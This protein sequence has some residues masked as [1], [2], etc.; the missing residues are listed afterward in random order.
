MNALR[1][2]M[3]YHLPSRWTLKTPLGT[4]GTPCEH[5]APPSSP[6]RWSPMKATLVTPVTRPPRAGAVWLEGSAFT[7]VVTLPFGSTLEIRPPRTGSSVLPVY[8]AAA[9]DACVHRPTVELVPPR[10]PSARYGSPSGPKVSPRGLLN[11]VAKVE[12]TGGV[13]CPPCPWP[14][15]AWALPPG[16][17]ARRRTAPSRSVSSW[18]PFQGDLRFA[19]C[20]P[21]TRRGSRPARTWHRATDAAARRSLA[22]ASAGLPDRG[23]EATPEAGSPSAPLG[24]VQMTTREHERG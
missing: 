18:P 17:R 4:V 24:T 10:P 23:A 11:P 16:R 14:P 22:E 6:Y 12:T 3:S 8:G 13:G 5:P 19:E 9:P 20:G 2:A 15:D 1:S 7:T 21:P